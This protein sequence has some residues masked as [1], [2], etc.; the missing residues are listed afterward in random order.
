[1]QDA[2]DTDTL[3]LIS[4]VLDYFSESKVQRDLEIFEQALSKQQDYVDLVKLYAVFAFIGA[5][6]AENH[7]E[8]CRNGK[9][10]RDSGLELPQI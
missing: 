3:Q 2:F 1:M 8:T 5:S 10:G 6:N 9:S 7:S 4:K